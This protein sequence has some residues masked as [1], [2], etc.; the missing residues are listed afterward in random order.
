MRYCPSCKSE[1]EDSALM[2]G[3]CKI[4][5]VDSIEEA[6]LYKQ[7]LKV[8]KFELEK[9]EGYLEYTNIYDYKV[10][11][12][13]GIA[14]I[15]VSEELYEKAHKFVAVYISE[16]MKDEKNEDDYFFDEYK[17]EN[18]GLK[19]EV[20]DMKGS[21]IAFVVLGVGL[22]AFSIL[23]FAGF[24]DSPFSQNKL[25]LGVA[26]VFGLISLYTALNTNKKIKYVE[27][28]VE[29][30]ES[31]INSILDEFRERFDLDTYLQDKSLDLENQDD[32]AKYFIIFD[33]IKVDLRNMYPDEA[34]S[35]I[36]S[37]ADQIYEIINKE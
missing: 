35:I 1:Y 19:T 11:E 15:S 14:I 21:V 4:D 18:I 23:S 31:K 32:G 27:K 22:I 29:E 6:K 9:L 5:L 3:E 17:T 33:I 25:M 7:L 36:N 30:K 13:D 20:S 37:V 16:N 34:E 24:I 26:F 12:L 28:D 8:K 10:E 2:C